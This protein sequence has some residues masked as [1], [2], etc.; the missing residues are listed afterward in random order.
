MINLTAK[1]VVKFNLNK[2]ILILINISWLLYVIKF[3][4]DDTDYLH[5]LIM[6]HI[7][8]IDKEADLMLNLNCSPSS[9]FGKKNIEKQEMMWGFCTEL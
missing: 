5:A 4:P 9:L 3:F 6:L 7:N 1:C 8:L 2:S